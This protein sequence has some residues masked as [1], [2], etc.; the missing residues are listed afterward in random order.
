MQFSR[1]SYST[2]LLFYY[3]YIRVDGDKEIRTPDPLLARQVLSQLSYTPTLLSNMRSFKKSRFI[4]S[5]QQSCSAFV[6]QAI[7]QHKSFLFS[8]ER[9]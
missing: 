8:L 7:K 6:E 4:L 1:F 3:Y 5:A 2:I 9:R